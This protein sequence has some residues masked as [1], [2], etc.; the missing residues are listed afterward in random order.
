MLALSASILLLILAASRSMACLFN[1]E[2]YSGYCEQL[3]SQ[4]SS[5]APQLKTKDYSCMCNQ[6]VYSNHIL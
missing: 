1:T 5:C 3:V 6:A 4:Y 2:Y